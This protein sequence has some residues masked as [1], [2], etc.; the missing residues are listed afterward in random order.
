MRLRRIR[1]FSY[2][3]NSSFSTLYYSNFSSKPTHKTNIYFNKFLVHCNSLITRHG[4]NGN[5]DQSELIFNRMPHKNVVSYT[6][7]LTV[8]ANNGQITKAR[9]LFDEMPERNI[10]SYNAMITAYIRNNCLVDE[11]FSLFSGMDERNA[12]SYGTMITGFL[13]A[14]MFDKAEQLYADMPLKL[15]DTVCSNAMIGGLMKGGRLE[16]AIRVFE[17][18]VE[19]DAVSWSSMID[20]Y[21]KKGM[22][23]EARELFDRMPIPMR[24]VVTWTCM[25]DGYINVDSFDDAFCLFLSMRRETDVAVNPTTLTIIFDACGEF[26]R[27][28]E[29]M[30]LHGFVIHMGFEFDTYLGNSMIAM[31]CRFGNLAGANQIFQT[32][33]QK[34]V[35]SWNSMIA[36]YVHYDE[37][38]EAYRLFKDMPRKDLV[39]WTSVIAGLFSKGMIQKGSQMF[40]MMPD[41]DDIAWTAVI[42]GF[43]SNGEY[44]KAFRWFIQMLKESVKP[45]SMTLSSVLT[46]SAGLATLNQ[47]LQIHAHVV[48]MEMQFD[49]SIQNSLISM[50]SKCGNV[51]EAYQVFSNI[52]APNVISFNSMINGLSQNGHGSEALNL[53]SQMQWKPNEITFLG[54]LSACSHEGLVEE[55]RRYFNIMKSVYKIEAGVDHY[56]CMVDLLGRAGLLDEAVDLIK[57]MPFEGHAGVWGAILGASRIHFRL[58]LAKL[59]A[60][61]LCEL[62]PEN[63]TPYVVLSNLYNMVG[64]RKDGNQV[65]MVKKSKRI[66][67]NP[68]C[69][70]IILKD[71]LHLFVAGDKSHMDLESI[72]LTLHIITKQISSLHSNDFSCHLF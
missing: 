64:K 22:I 41:K 33:N 60:E 29:A 9:R 57:S 46:A 2:Q 21:C 39:S 37:I 53:F 20:G 15:R 47:G 65:R 36:G 62:E 45:N 67:K 68:G 63:A 10:T 42:S 54:I 50:Y 13:R 8:Y 24:N 4:L 3:H 28:R 16:E 69:S 25:I 55:G 26:G 38:E 19:R 56:G 7:M 61:H 14:G 49:L 5:V 58:D 1:L 32:M 66:K 51:A 30:Q 71:K 35:V 31:L 12:V 72:K 70:W 40:I 6:S 17:S 34:D 11:A 43:V 48:K 59:A 44:E 27:F 18:M 52:S 23:T